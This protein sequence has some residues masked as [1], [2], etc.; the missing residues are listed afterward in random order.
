MAACPIRERPLSADVAGSDRAGIDCAIL[1]GVRASSIVLVGCI[2][3]VVAGL[4]VI[5]S[6]LSASTAP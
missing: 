4:T 3:F 1:S 6:G 5:F 2:V